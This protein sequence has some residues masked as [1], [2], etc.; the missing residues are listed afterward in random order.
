MKKK[1]V[2][3][4]VL[5]TIIG[6]SV[7][8]AQSPTLDKLTFTLTNN[9]REAS[10]R[11]VNNQV[12]G[13]IVIPATYNGLPV[14]ALAQ[15]AFQ[16]NRN[17]TSV[18]FLGNNLRTI[19]NWALS[20]LGITSIIIPASV[21]SIAQSFTNYSNSSAFT[22]ITFMGSSTNFTANSFSPGGADLLAKYQAGGAGTYT[23]R[24]GEN[25]WIKQGGQTYT[26]PPP[27]QQ[28]PQQLPQ[29]L[30]QQSTGNK[31]KFEIASNVVRVS[32]ADYSI[33]GD[34]VIPTTYDNR[35]VQRI[36]DNGFRNCTYIT[37][38]VIP[39]S[40]T[41]IGTYAFAGCQNLTTITFGG[42]SATTYS[43]T[44]DGDLRTKWQAGGAGT[45]QRNG[46][47]WTKIY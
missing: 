22:S 17:V 26:P 30:P 32:A 33:S 20:A 45:Y 12:S 23:R 3:S 16:N 39:P 15:S 5:L 42:S 9:N 43:S 35:P 19:G 37:N 13:A 8:F 6:V 18:T 27:Q 41:Y 10:V 46:N 28:Q 21:E 31:I 24:P 36:V 47:T 7:V 1:V 25:I 34:V 29:Q 40:I 2:V 14:T 11:Q 44:F 38:V 4:L